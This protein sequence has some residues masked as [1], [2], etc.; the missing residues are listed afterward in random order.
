MADEIRS[1]EDKLSSM[2]L[3]NSFAAET[4]IILREHFIYLSKL[5][6]LIRQIVSYIFLVETKFDNR[7]IC[8][9]YKTICDKCIYSISGVVI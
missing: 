5:N 9:I 4:R 3:E 7:A 2:E 1:R 8:K 6:V